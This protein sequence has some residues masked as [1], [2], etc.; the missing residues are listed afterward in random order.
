MQ[1]TQ[2]LLLFLGILSFVR[3]LVVF[4]ECD[5]MEVVISNYVS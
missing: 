5:K 4:K 1:F 3:K 2:I